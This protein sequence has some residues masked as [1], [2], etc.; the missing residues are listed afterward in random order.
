[1]RQRRI[2]WL[3]GLALVVVW[4][5]AA[6]AIRVARAQKMTAEK[7][8]AYVQQHRLA[9]LDEAG[10]RKVLEGLADRV[11]RLTIEE[12][13]KFRHDGPMRELY[14]SM[15]DAERIRYLEMTLPKGMKQMMEAF[16]TMEPAK[17]K[18]IVNRALADLNRARAE[19]GPDAEDRLHTRLTDQTA[20]KFINEG[21]KSFLSDANAETK[22]DLQPLIE[23]MQVIMQSGQSMQPR[24]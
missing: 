11:N 23:Q 6:I 21:M 14:E 8:V 15:S 10:R 22:L 13:Q 3:G 2:W 7:T 20:Q 4:A 19:A 12:R 1:M 17:R 5:V 24:H 9:G 16:N 18:E